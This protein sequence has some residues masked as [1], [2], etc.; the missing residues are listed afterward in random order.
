MKTKFVYLFNYFITGYAGKDPLSVAKVDMIVDCIEDI[1][2]KT[3]EHWALPDGEE[4]VSN[5]GFNS[6]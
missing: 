3:P 6:F 4:R 5:V 2:I 1:A